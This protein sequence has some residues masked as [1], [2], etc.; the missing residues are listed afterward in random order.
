MSDLRSTLKQLDVQGAVIEAFRLIAQAQL[1][2]DGLLQLAIDLYEERC[3]ATAFL[4]V[5]N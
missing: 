2:V 4:V 5:N 1:T 3:D